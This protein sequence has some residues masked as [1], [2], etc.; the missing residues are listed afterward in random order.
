MKKVLLGG[1]ALA[2]AV[3]AATPASAADVTSGLEL[4]ISGFVGFQAALSL[5]D[6]SNGTRE[7]DGA[8]VFNNG[9]DRDYDFQSDVRLIFDI[10]NVTDSG[11]EYGGRIRFDRVNRQEDVVVDQTYVYVE[12]SF[13]RFTFGDGPSTAEDF[14]YRY[15]HDEL[16]GDLG[17]GSGFGDLLDGDYALGGGDFFSIDASFLAGLGDDTR[18]KYTSPSFG[19]F[20]FGI[21]FAPVV[22]GDN[23]AGTSGRDDLFDDDETFYE[24]VVVAGVDYEQTFDAVSVRVGGSAA[25]G[26]GVR[27]SDDGANPNGNH[28]EVYTL[29]AQL[30]SGGITGSVNWVHNESVAV[31]DTPVD[32]ILGDLSYQFG[33]FLASV[34]YAYTFAERG[35]GLESQV[36]DGED[37][38][39]N[40]LAG[41][42][43]TYNLAPGLNTYGEVIYEKQ[44][45][46][47]GRDFENATFGTGIVLG[48]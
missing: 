26:S 34:S 40:H 21:D 31:A 44:N 13:G 30:G 46:R 7:D 15:A 9:L 48:F 10:R 1:T 29:G 38:K 35:N 37:L 16:S 14:G 20:S 45:F 47:Q 4:K 43:L 19:G 17:L 8:F 42:N 12:G 41:V 3:M 6:N 18:I 32:T 23:H 28:L 33:P 39:D 36:T 11:L 25:Y 24:N 22:G 27:T 2:A 5:S